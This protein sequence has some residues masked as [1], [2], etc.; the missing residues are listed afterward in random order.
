MD[1]KQIFAFDE[2]VYYDKP[3]RIVVYDNE[4]GMYCTVPKQDLSFKDKIP[5][6]MSLNGMMCIHYW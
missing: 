1:K 6:V 4:F 3:E 5:L 2:I